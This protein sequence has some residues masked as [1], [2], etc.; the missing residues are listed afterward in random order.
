MGDDRR[1]PA[2]AARPDDAAGR[3]AFGDSL[4][5]ALA[6]D[7]A[8]GVFYVSSGDGVET[9][10]PVTHA[11]QHFSNV[12]VD[13]LEIAPDGDLWGTSW[14][15][16]GDVISFDSHGRAQVQVRLDAGGRLDRVRRAGT[17]LE[18]LLFVSARIPSGS[19]DPANLTM[20][21]LA[22]LQ[23][24]QVARGGPSAEQLL[25]TS[26]G[27][28]LV[29][30]RLAGRRDR[31]AGRAVGR[32]HEPGRRQPRRAAALDASRSR[33]TATCGRRRRSDPAS[34]VNPAN[35]TLVDSTGDARSTAPQVSYD[36]ESRTTTLRFESPPATRTR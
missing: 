9:F 20:V 29:V 21:D 13:D 15:N 5:Q 23:T 14:P 33:S 11:F 24:L 16:R 7:A 4:T 26:D 35:Y 25:A 36:P 22:T 18:G 12:R 19:T 27:R 1:R 3:P 10:D 31:A 2:A 28:L 34:V 30:E 8:K 17:P 6:F 32:A